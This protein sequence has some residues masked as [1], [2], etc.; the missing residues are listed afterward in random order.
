MA[1]YSSLFQRFFM[2]WVEETQ[3]IAIDNFIQNFSMPVMN[4]LK[5]YPIIKFKLIIY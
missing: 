5:M 3:T 4:V 1:H 2:Y